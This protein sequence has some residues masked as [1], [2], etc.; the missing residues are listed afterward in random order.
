MVLKA[1]V[2]DDSPDDLSCGLVNIAAQRRLF[3]A[4]FLCLLTRGFAQSA[5]QISRLT[6]PQLWQG[7][8]LGI[9]GVPSVGNPFDPD[10]IRL[11]PSFTLPSA[12][13]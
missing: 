13:S 12:R 5:P 1:F 9:N 8:E 6:S 7:L 10:V 11:D 3:A 4:V 2:A